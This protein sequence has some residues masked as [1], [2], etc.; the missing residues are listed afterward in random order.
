MTEVFHIERF[1]GTG[2]LVLIG[3]PGQ[4]HCGFCDVG[5]DWFRGSTREGGG[6]WRTVKFD[7]SVHRI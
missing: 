6:F 1:D 4:P 3:S 7:S 2:S 5:Y